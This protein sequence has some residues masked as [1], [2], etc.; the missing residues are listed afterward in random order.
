MSNSTHG[1]QRPRNRLTLRACWEIDGLAKIAHAHLQHE[2]GNEEYLPVLAMLRRVRRLASVQM[3]ALTDPNE[4][5]ASL[6]ARLEETGGSE[7]T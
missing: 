1:A 2:D 5:L 7:A 4:D 6:T 3:S